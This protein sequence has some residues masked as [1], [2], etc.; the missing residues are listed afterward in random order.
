MNEYIRNKKWDATTSSVYV[1]SHS[2]LSN[3][4]ASKLLVI[5]LNELKTYT[6]IKTYTQIFTPNLFMFAKTWT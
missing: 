5:Y 6:Y 3:N 1:L 4:F 2:I